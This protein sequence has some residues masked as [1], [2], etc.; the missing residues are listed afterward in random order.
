M[1]EKIIMDFFLT[2]NNIIVNNW[3]LHKTNKNR[4]KQNYKTKARFVIKISQ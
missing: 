3:S 1:R 2:A 4:E